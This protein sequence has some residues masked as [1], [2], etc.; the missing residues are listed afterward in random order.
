MNFA[1]GTKRRKN[2]IIMHSKIKDAQGGDC[3]TCGALQK[4][5]RNNTFSCSAGFFEIY[6]P[7]ANRGAEK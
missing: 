5:N 4:Q 7:A 2:K 3:G 6:F 1:A